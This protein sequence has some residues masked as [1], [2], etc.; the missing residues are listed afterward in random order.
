M[1][2]GRPLTHVM[3]TTIRWAARCKPVRTPPGSVTTGIALQP[4]AGSAADSVTWLPVHC[5][6]TNPPGVVWMA[7]TGRVP[8]GGDGVGLGVGVGRGVGVGVGVGATT[9]LDDGDRGAEDD[10]VALVGVVAAAVAPGADV[11]P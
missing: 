2:A 3:W 8:C 1:K 11:V 6:I 4:S 9:E 7:R 5:P 10:A